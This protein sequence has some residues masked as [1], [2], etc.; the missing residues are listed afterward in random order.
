MIASIF[1]E[2]I[3]DTLIES[4]NDLCDFSKKE[5]IYEGSLYVYQREKG[6]LAQKRHVILTHQGLYITNR[7][8]ASPGMEKRF[9]TVKIN[10]IWSLVYF[11]DCKEFE[12][13]AESPFRF[14]ISFILND[15]I[16]N[17][18]LLS[19]PCF[20][21]WKEFLEKVGIQTNFETKFTMHEMLG[22]GSCSPVYRIVHN[23]TKISFACKVFKKSNLMDSSL[24]LKGLINE[25]N[26]LQT[27]KN[28]PNILYLEEIHECE[29]NVY[30]ITEYIQGKKIFQNRLSYKLHEIC[31]IVESLLSALVFLKS[32][33]ILHRDIKPDNLL[34]KYKDKSLSLNEVKIID[35]G[36]ATFIS[37]QDH[38]YN[39]CG[40]V[41]YIAPEILN[42]SNNC[43]LTV[44]A[45]MYSLGI[46]LY[47]FISGTKAF[48]IGSPKTCLRSNQIGTVDLFDLNFTK[49]S[50]Y[51][52]LISKRF[53][54]SN[55]R[56]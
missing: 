33:G 15:N 56:D 55:G 9:V 12:A 38:I 18:Y 26:I 52:Y 3:R 11:V 24:S 46:V 39:K 8:K 13:I 7:K 16:A 2:I 42:S 48:K 29:K 19:L 44:A 4:I 22:K 27:V 21:K 20:L 45:D 50:P 30:L 54:H 14:K 6:S 5:I 28:H 43:K 49:N 23:E 47:N 37:D 17:F 31:N 25:I 32:K 1:E 51:S 34:L 36:L 53:D 40:T 10:T 35:F 41:G